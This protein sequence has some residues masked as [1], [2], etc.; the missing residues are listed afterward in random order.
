MRVVLEKLPYYTGETKNTT[1][2]ICDIAKMSD[3]EVVL[4]AAK[5]AQEDVKK[6][7]TAKISNAIFPATVG[8]FIIDDLIKAKGAP[9]LKLAAG[10]LSL[11]SW[12][13]FIKSFDVAG[14][15]SDKISQKTDNENAKNAISIFGKIGGGFAIYAGA[16]KLIKKGIDK[17]APKLLPQITEKATAFDNAFASNRIVKSISKN[18]IKPIKEFGSN[19]P[20]LAKFAHNNS[21]L[22]IAG[23]SILSAIGLAAKLANKQEEAFKNNVGNMLEKREEARLASDVIGQAEESYKTSIND[24]YDIDTTSIIET[25]ENNPKEL[26]RVVTETLM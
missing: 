16:S 21:K 11:A 20:K 2:K 26:D 7:K 22:F 13:V 6:S 15:I 9:S 19:H 8:A 24:R 10:G 1:D 3:S 18:I 12:L 4:S 25:A 5:K 23:A 14:K 17:L